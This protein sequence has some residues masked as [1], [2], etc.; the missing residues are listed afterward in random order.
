[1]KNPLLKKKK[2]KALRNIASEKSASI[3]HSIEELLDFVNANESIFVPENDADVVIY[4]DEMQDH[5]AL[6]SKLARSLK[7]K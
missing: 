3:A 7:K 4:E 2:K 6:Y 1:M 5:I